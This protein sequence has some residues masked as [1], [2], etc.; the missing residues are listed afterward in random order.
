M[1]VAA[2]LSSN[3]FTWTSLQ[4]FGN[5]L[6]L[7]V[8][9]G[10]L[11]R[12]DP[13]KAGQP[14]IYRASGVDYPYGSPIGN[15]FLW[16]GA[17][18][19]TAQNN[20]PDVDSSNALFVGGTTLEGQTIFSATASLQKDTRNMLSVDSDAVLRRYGYIGDGHS[21]PLS[22]ITSFA[23]QATTG[24]TLAQWQA[25]LPIATALTDEADWV[26]IQS[27]FAAQTDEESVRIPPGSRAVSNHQISCSPHH[28]CSITGTSPS[29]SSILFTNPASG[30]AGIMH[31]PN[32]EDKWL[33]LE[34]IAIM[35]NVNQPNNAAVTYKLIG[36]LLGVALPLHI[37]HVF[38]GPNRMIYPFSYYWN[39]GLD[40]YNTSG[41]D[42]TENEIVG[43]S[44]DGAQVPSLGSM[45]CDIRMTAANAST[46]VVDEPKIM[47]NL[48]A[49]AQTGI[50]ISGDS[51]YP[52]IND[53]S[54]GVL[55][56]GSVIST[57][58]RLKPIS[59]GTTLRQ[60]SQESVYSSR[61]LARSTTT[62]LL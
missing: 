46:L 2:I 52:H 50:C 16:D 9:D 32:G 31:A 30:Q 36:V 14:A 47:R 41:A 62:I 44:V 21:H 18:S 33:S 54:I 51:E 56:S 55:T 12:I 34:N 57:T 5:L 29:S 45:L 17:D 24:W 26:A 15:A 27:V 13:P 48:L 39:V 22:R 60:H 7:N 11:M 23:G 20:N 1:A 53:N 49:Q 19:V 58:A 10:T 42:I 35:T 61:R 8:S 38:I 25:V 6:T 40:V 37:H 3:T 4:A 59:L 28:A 43:R